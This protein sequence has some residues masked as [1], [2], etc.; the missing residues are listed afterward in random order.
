MNIR[1]YMQTEVT[2]ISSNVFVSDAE[3]IMSDHNIQ[4][5]PVIDNGR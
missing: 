1:E 2:N 4:R 5:L 3:K